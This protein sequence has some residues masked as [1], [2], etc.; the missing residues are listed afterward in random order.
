MEHRATDVAAFFQPG[1][2][3]PPDRRIFLAAARLKVL[4]QRQRLVL[5]RAAALYDKFVDFAVDSVSRFEQLVEPDEIVKNHVGEILAEDRRTVIK[6][7][8]YQ[9]KKIRMLRSAVI[10]GGEAMQVFNMAI[11]P[12]PCFDLPIFCADF[13]T[14]SSRSIFVL[15]LN[16]LYNVEAD[17]AYKDKYYSELLPLV[18]KH[19]KLLPWGEKLT[20]ESLQFFSPIVLWS[21]PESNK[22]VDEAIYLAFQDYIMAWTRIIGAATS[23]TDIDAICRNKVAHHRYL[24]WR[25]SKDPGRPVLRRLLGEDRCEHYIHEFLF[26]G[27]HDLGTSSFTEYFPE[28]RCEDGTVNTARSIIGKSYS[29]RPWNDTG[30]FIHRSG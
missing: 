24:T 4:R 25:A 26:N 20:G 29:E 8:A 7:H 21:K 13:F 17:K 30:T 1:A 14:S 18:K 3:F 11:F 15:D 10:D 22:E 28:Y 16:P 27:L 2:T 19:S 5:L 23:E 12:R 6:S 9:S